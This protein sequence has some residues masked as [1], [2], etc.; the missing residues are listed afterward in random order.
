MIKPSNHCYI[1]GSYGFAGVRAAEKASY[2]LRSY[3]RHQ[4][5]LANVVGDSFD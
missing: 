4:V 2:P 3:F 1:I 5:Y